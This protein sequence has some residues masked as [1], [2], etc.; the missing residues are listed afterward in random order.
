MTEEEVIAMVM[1]SKFSTPIWKSLSQQKSCQLHYFMN[2]NLQTTHAKIF[3][4]RRSKDARLVF[5]TN[6][7]VGRK[8]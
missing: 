1:T 5:G 3:I 8:K 4:G 7:Y 2:Q 6:I